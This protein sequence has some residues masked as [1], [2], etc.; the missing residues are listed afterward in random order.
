VEIAGDVLNRSANE[1]YEFSCALLG[2]GTLVD[3]RETEPFALNER[4]DVTRS[5]FYLNSP[6]SSCYQG[7]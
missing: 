1:G 6:K 2:L 7:R 3:G 4:F 5:A